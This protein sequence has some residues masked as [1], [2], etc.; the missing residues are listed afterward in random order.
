MRYGAR[1]H[2]EA[3]PRRCEVRGCGSRPQEWFESNDHVFDVCSAH[4]LQLRAGEALTIEGDEILVGPEA[5]AEI[6]DVR[7]ATT[8]TGTVL[9]LRLGHHGVVDQEVPLKVTST[10][11][12]SIRDLLRTDDD[13]GA[14]PKR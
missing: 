5:A 12:A 6:L 2:A 10:F 3:F 8:P 4:G 9:T 13:P 7:T 1:E 14:D 11:R